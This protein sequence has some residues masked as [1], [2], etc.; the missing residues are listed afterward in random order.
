MRHLLNVTDEERQE[1]REQ[2]LGTTQKDFK[3]FADALETVRGADATSASVASADAAKKACEER[4]E[5]KF[6]VKSVM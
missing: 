3:N 1:R 4:P 2:I 5:L 6:V